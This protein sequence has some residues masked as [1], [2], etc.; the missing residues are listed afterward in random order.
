MEASASSVMS[1]ADVSKMMETYMAKQAESTK[2]ILKSELKTNNAELIAKQKEMIDEVSERLT[3]SFDSKLD[4]AVSSLRDQLRKEFSEQLDV[5][6]AQVNNII[7]IQCPVPSDDMDTDASDSSGVPQPS[8]KR[9]RAASNGPKVSSASAASSARPASLPPRRPVRFDLTKEDSAPEAKHEM[10]IGGLRRQVPK[11][12][13]TEIW[14][15]CRGRLPQ[16]LFEDGKVVGGYTLPFGLVEFS[17]KHNLDSVL[18]T[19]RALPSPLSWEDDVDEETK[20]LYF[21][22]NRTA[23]Q[24]TVGRFQSHFYKG[25][26]ALV[27]DAH[28]GTKLKIVNKRLHMVRGNDLLELLAFMPTTTGNHPFTIRVHAKN[29]N[30]IGLKEDAVDAMVVAALAAAKAE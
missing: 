8:Q 30:K 5:V 11:A 15:L 25:M 16:S 17:S 29:V 23:E 26:Q 20:A 27:E 28:P 9:G 18:E 3:E 19:L 7:P 21:R 24:L 12:I 22:K 4:A 13:R 14:E 10:F 6:K 2:H 1:T